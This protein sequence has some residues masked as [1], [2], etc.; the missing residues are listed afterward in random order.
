M[1]PCDS[2]RFKESPSAVSALN[3]MR[4]GLS[5]DT[6]SATSRFHTYDNWVR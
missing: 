2:H 1:T 4:L 3:L 5:L 6:F